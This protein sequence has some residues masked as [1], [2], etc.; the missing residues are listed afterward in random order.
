MTSGKLQDTLVFLDHDKERQMVQEWDV[1]IVG[2]GI[3]GLSC[4]HF[5]RRAGFKVRVLER[6]P[7][8]N[9]VGAGLQ[10]APNAQA[11][12]RELKLLDDLLPLSWPLHKVELRSTHSGLLATMDAGQ[13]TLLAIHRA[14]LQKLLARDLDADMLQFG[15]TITAMHEEGDRVQVTLQSGETLTGKLRIGADGLRSQVRSQFFP[16]VTFRYSGTSSYRGIAH[17]PG[18]LKDP[19]QGAEIWGPGCRFG[20]SQITSTDIYWYLT[21]DAPPQEQRSPGDCH[22]HALQLMDHF[23][24]QKPIVARTSFEHLIHTD[25]SD[26]KP[27][28]NWVRGRVALLGDAAHA[29]TPNLGQGA[30][31]A[32]EDAW[33]LGLTLQKFDAEPI[34]LEAYLAVRED[35]ALWIVRQSWTF[36]SICHLK[37]PWQQTLRDLCVKYAPSGLQ[38]ASLARMYKPEVGLPH[39]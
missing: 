16:A 26:I 7:G 28:A 18:L 5:L 33:A 31:Q 1:I 30:A 36:Q 37:K 32:I 35:K 23:P 3:G 17:A 2:G 4:A 25:I 10:L 14:Q 22:A 9:E 12:F 6:C 27:T 15:V 29:T 8:L 20:Y 39:P 13:E 21:F 38:K 19:H 24:E 11:A 34:A